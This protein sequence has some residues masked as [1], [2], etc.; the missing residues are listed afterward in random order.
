MVPGSPLMA[1]PP[2]VPTDAAEAMQDSFTAFWGDRDGAA[3]RLRISVERILDAE[4]I[5]R[6]GTLNDRITEF[7][8]KHP[9][10]ENSLHALRH[11]GNVGSHEG[12]A[13]AA[14][15]FS[16]PLRSTRNGCGTT[17]EYSDHIKALADKLVARRGRY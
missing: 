6:K 3:N 15:S 12:D 9:D 17:M 2:S 1:I 7:G 11:V 4:A 14:R 13:A 16:T 10:M 5:S 8:K